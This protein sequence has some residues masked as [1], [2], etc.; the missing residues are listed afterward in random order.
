MIRAVIARSNG[1]K[2]ILLGVDERNI[3][4]LKAGKPI[5]VECD[6]MGIHGIE[7]A[8]LYGETPQ[9]IIDEL[10]QVGIDLPIDRMPVVTPD[11]PVVFKR[12]E[13]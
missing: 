4:C 8:I 1:T 10:R 2:M 9:H 5:H 12:K 6:P 13:P 11:H 7:I 3:E